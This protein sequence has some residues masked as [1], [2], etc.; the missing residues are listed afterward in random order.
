M[1]R[2]NIH[3]VICIITLLFT[4]YIVTQVKAD[5]VDANS[6]NQL[7]PSQREPPPQIG[8]TPE[9]ISSDQITTEN[10]KT[11]LYPIILIFNILYTVVSY[12]WT[13]ILYIL[14][15]VFWILS[16]L[17]NTF[18]LTPYTITQKIN[19]YFYPLY[20]FLATAALLGI[21]IGGIAGWF[22]EVITRV[23]ITPT[24]DELNYF[25]QGNNRSKAEK[26]KRRAQALANFRAKN[27]RM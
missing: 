2:R 17:Y 22:S 19:A 10:I 14:S 21:L 20:V 4:L 1:N 11:L 25:E 18:I 13:I 6:N 8:D 26:L 24:S 12:I 3:F 15:P 9:N 23:L 7:P 5:A 16:V 27:G